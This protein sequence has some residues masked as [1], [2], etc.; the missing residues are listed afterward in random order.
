MTNHIQMCE[1]L[2]LV[3]LIWLI[4]SILAI[5]CL[6]QIEQERSEQEYGI[7]SNKEYDI[8]LNHIFGEK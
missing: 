1:V 7:V 8:I 6:L 2:L 5:N 4:R 3:C